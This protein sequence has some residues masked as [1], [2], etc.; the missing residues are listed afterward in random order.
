[1][2]RLHTLT[3]RTNAALG[4]LADLQ[5]RAGDA[6]ASTAPAIVRAAL[7]DLSA[8]LSELQTATEQLHVHEEELLASR[9]RVV[10]VERRLTEF[11]QG[12]PLAAIWTDAQGVILEA[13]ESAAA[14]LN[15]ARPRLPGKPLMLFLSDRQAFFEALAALQAPGGST[16]ELDMLVRPRERKP[17]VAKVTGRVL[18]HDTRWCWFLREA[19]EV[20]VQTGAPEP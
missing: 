3:V 17:R 9:A 19:G 14:L 8:A 20:D 2:S 11:V 18:A 12:L 4:R 15:V 13:N 7:K 5:R 6:S 1:M 10:D 16:V